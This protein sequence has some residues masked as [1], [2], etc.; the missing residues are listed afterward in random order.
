MG[1][2]F[3][4]PLASAGYQPNYHAPERPCGDRNHDH[5]VTPAKR[6]SSAL[7]NITREPTYQAV[8]IA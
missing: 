3:C 5:A 8:N 6:W 4:S 2:A 1:I 7:E